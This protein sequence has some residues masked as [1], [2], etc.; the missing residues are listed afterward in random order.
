MDIY[1]YMGALPPSHHFNKTLREFPSILE[2]WGNFPPTFLRKF[3]SPGPISLYIYI[4][5]YPSLEL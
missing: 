3:R 5:I 4:F 1:I 2:L